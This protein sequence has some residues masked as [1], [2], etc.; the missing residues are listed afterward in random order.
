MKKGFAVKVG[1]WLIAGLLTF[2][3]PAALVYAKYASGPRIPPDVM[4]RFKQYNSP[5]YIVYSDLP[6]EKV[7]AAIP[8]MNAIFRE[9]ATRMK[10]FSGHIAGKFPFFMI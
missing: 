10:G 1:T 4:A 9:Y 8:R 7:E 5:Y 3:I 6:P 2:A